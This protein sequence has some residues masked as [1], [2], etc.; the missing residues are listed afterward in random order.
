MT[1][2]QLLFNSP[3]E[4]T[5]L[6]T[7]L[8]RIIPTVRDGDVITVSNQ[9]HLLRVKKQLASLQPG[10]DVNVRLHVEGTKGN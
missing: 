6:E 9:S 8:K 5:L 10:R 4:D 1:D 3:E 7:I 2:I